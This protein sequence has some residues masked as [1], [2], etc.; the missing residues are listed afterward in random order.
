[1]GLVGRDRSD[2]RVVRLGS[3]RS[4]EESEVIIYNVVINRIYLEHSGDRG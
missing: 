3:P 2:Q 1:M 4:P